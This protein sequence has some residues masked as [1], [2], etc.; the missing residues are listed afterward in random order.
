MGER[1]ARRRD[2]RAH[3]VKSFQRVIHGLTI[4]VSTFNV[5]LLVDVPFVVVFTRQ[6]S[7]GTVCMFNQMSVSLK[8]NTCTA[9]RVAVLVCVLGKTGLSIEFRGKHLSQLIVVCFTYV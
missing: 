1:I 7:P 6:N 5:C 4:K 2:E 3:T 9:F 8:P